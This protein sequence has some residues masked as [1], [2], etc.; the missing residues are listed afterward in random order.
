MQ[1]ER[2]KIREEPV[3]DGSMPMQRLD[4]NDWEL[5]Q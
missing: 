4:P 2:D 3:C 1:S 5:V